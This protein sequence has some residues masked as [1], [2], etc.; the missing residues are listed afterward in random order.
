MPPTDASTNITPATNGPSQARR[1]GAAAVVLLACLGLLGVGYTLKP[2]DVG[3]GTHTQLGLPPCGFHEYVR[4]P[5]ATCGMTTAVSLAAHGRLATAFMAQP[6]GA[7]LAL[8]AAM[9]AWISGYALWRDLDLWT[10]IGPLW[11]PL[12]L[13]VIGLVVLGAWLFKVAMTLGGQ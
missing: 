7:A 1:R 6:A 2:A 11:R 13:A 12:T 3:L 8:G 9:L 4:V 10:V 5:C